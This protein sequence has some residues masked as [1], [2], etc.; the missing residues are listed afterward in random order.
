MAL[1]DAE[2]GVNGITTFSPEHMALAIV[3]V[4]LLV[5]PAHVRKHACSPMLDPVG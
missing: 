5:T 4:I 3:R 1:R 2:L